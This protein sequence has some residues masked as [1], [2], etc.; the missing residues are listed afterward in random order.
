MYVIFKN[1]SGTYPIQ[2]DTEVLFARF[3]K[4]VKAQEQSEEC[5][6]DQVDQLVNDFVCQCLVVD[7][8]RVPEAA[9]V[10]RMASIVPQGGYTHFYH[11]T[12]QR[13]NAVL[14][15]ISDHGLRSR[16]TPFPVCWVGDEQPSHEQQK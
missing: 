1:P 6:E 3:K 8:Y 2:V 7:K 5:C 14:K 16:G 11:D 12:D 9:F 4:L 13:G 15:A 10:V